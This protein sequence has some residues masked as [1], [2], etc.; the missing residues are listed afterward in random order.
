MS[1][2]CVCFACFSAIKSRKMIEKLKK[3]YKSHFFTQITI[4]NTIMNMRWVDNPSPSVTE[5]ARWGVLAPIFAYFMTGLGKSVHGYYKTP[6]DGVHSPPGRFSKLPLKSLPPRSYA[7]VDPLN[8]I[9]KTFPVCY[10]PHLWGF[11]STQWVL[12]SAQK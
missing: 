5:Q 11:C 10:E 1:I 8:T 6:R 9:L 12:Q 3:N 4:R 2:F 7:A